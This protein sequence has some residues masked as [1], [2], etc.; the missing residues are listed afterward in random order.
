MTDP[1]TPNRGYI[2]PA[3]NADIN[4][5]DTP[6]NANWSELDNNL[7]GVSAIALTNVDVVL[8]SAQYQCGTIRFS[9]IL[10]GNV[11]ITFPSVQG[12]WSIENLTT[13]AFTVSLTC[14]GGN[15][16]CAPPGQAIDILTDG[17]NTKFRNLDKIGAYWDYAGATVPL[18]V[19]GCT[20]PPYLLCDGSS[21]SAVT[22]P[23]LNTIL[24]GTTLPDARA[25]VRIPL[26]G[27]TNRVTTAGSGI[28][29][30]TRLSAGGAQNVTL[31]TTMI[32][33]HNHAITDPGHTHSPPAGAFLDNSGN[34][35]AFQSGASGSFASATA[36]ATTGISINNTGGGLSHQNMQPTFVFGITLI[37]AA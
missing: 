21:F 15:N 13:G 24:G 1:T 11:N 19:S 7:G 27:G 2:I 25:R 37:R 8:N 26:D 23:Y 3:N 35:N 16:I 20:V 32:P 6:L 31:D 5:W 10:T 12:W 33:A 29:G 22:Y 9:G 34:N 14:G 28:D 30:A 36:S 18:W 4:T 17:T